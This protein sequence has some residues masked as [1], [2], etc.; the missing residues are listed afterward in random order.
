M[1]RTVILKGAQFGLSLPILLS[2]MDKDFGYA[3]KAPHPVG[4][5]TRGGKAMPLLDCPLES[6]VPHTRVILLSGYSYPITRQ[7]CPKS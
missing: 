1:R 5:S 6:F 3:E 2:S 7:D 4:T